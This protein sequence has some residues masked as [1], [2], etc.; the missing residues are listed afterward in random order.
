[1]GATLAL[2]MPPV[3]RINSRML[4]LSVP[5]VA[6]KTRARHALDGV[7]P[8]PAGVLLWGVLPRSDRRLLE[9]GMALEAQLEKA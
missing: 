1:M 2:Y 5:S 8:L 9:Y 6:L 7:P 3:S 4:D